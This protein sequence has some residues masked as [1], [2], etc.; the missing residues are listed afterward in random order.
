MLSLA[1]GVEILR[2]TL[3]NQNVSRERK[4]DVEV[5]RRGHKN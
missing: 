3:T 1:L 2:D 5:S 4:K